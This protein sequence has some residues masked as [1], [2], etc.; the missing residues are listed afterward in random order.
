M[1][2]IIV[3]AVLVLICLA[4]WSRSTVSQTTDR[5]GEV[6][7][8]NT[9]VVTV[10]DPFQIE[11][12]GDKITD[13]ASDWSVRNR[14]DGEF[15][16]NVSKEGGAISVVLMVTKA[17]AQDMVVK[18]VSSSPMI[19]WENGSN[20][21]NIPI[22]VVEK[23]AKDPDGTTQDSKPTSI[24]GRLGYKIPSY[25]DGDWIKGMEPI[26]YVPVDTK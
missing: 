8:Y 18:G 9:S 24:Q 23:G 17:P 14:G 2:S 16:L 26:V 13:H 22:T 21:V 1:K 7:V 10:G 19:V 5:N 11:V 12:V 25:S 15:L 6:I 4:I 20:K 3:G